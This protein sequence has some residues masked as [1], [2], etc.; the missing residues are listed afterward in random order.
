MVLRDL[1]TI[2]GR[3]VRR[4]LQEFYRLIRQHRFTVVPLIVVSVVSIVPGAEILDQVPDIARR[5]TDGPGNFTLEGGFALLALIAFTATLFLVGRM[6]TAAAARSWEGRRVVTLP[7]APLE[8]WFI[9]PLVIFFIGLVAKALGVPVD[10]LRLGGGLCHTDRHRGL[11]QPREEN[12][13]RARVDSPEARDSAE[14]AHP[15]V[16]GRARLDHADWGTQL[17][18]A[19]W[20]SPGSL[21]YEPPSPSCCW[22]RRHDP[23]SSTALRLPYWWW[24]RLASFSPGQWLRTCWCA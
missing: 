15:V 12:Q 20:P 5:W 19:S 17:P 10:L 9:V 23:L 3:T 4:S 14:A 16:C 6:R 1:L 2:R 22:R 13:H 7:E 8:P 24:P 11:L 18:S 21:S